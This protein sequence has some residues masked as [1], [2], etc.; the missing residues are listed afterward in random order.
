MG[1]PSALG[2]N[3]LRLREARGLSQAALARAA[4]VSQALISRLEAG[5]RQDAGGALL[6]RIARALGVTVDELLRD[7]PQP[8]P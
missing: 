5:E 8:A 2:R 3:L 7:E 4:E 1:E 6:Q